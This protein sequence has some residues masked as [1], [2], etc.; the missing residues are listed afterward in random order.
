MKRKIPTTVVI[1][2]TGEHY[3]TE[4]FSRKEKISNR[5]MIMESRGR[6]MAEEKGTIEDDL[7]D[8]FGLLAGAIEELAFDTFAVAAELFELMPNT[9]EDAHNREIQCGKALEEGK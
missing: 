6:G 7:H 9:Y 4:I 8:D 5:N 1:T 3:K 2:I